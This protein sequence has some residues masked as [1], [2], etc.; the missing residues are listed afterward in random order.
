MLVG[1]VEFGQMVAEMVGVPADF[2]E[3]EEAGPGIERGIFEA[4]G[5]GGAGELLKAGD[6]IE[7]ALTQGRLGG[8]GIE[9]REESSDEIEE[10]IGEFGAGELRG[11]QGDDK[12][13]LFA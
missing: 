3:G 9:E 4:L 2:I 10:D 8:D 12:V 1:E 6:P 13:S 11:F 7:R 5:H